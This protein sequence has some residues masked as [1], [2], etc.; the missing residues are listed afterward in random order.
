MHGHRYEGEFENDRVNG[1]GLM[2]LASGN[3]YEGEF[4]DDQKHGQV[5]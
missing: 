4:R 3:T 2:T 5:Q 1:Y